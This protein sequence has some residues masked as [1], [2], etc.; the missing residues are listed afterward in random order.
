MS[1]DF[2][3]YQRT[4]LTDGARASLEAVAERSPKGEHRMGEDDGRSHTLDVAISNQA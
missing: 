4:K 1:K 2:I 3:G